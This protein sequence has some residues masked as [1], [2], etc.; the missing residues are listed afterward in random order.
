MPKKET[1]FSRQTV[2]R[3]APSP[4][5]RMHLGNVYTALAAWLCAKSA[6]GDFLLRIE[7]LDPVR[8]PRA[9]ADQILSDLEWLGITWDNPD[10][11]YQSERT[12]IY[13]KYYEQ[14]TGK[15][16]VY[17]CFCSRAQLH[18]A[19]APH[20][21][22]GRVVYAGT[23]RRLTDAEV[24]EKAKQR[25]PAARL[26]LPDTDITF[27]DGCYGPQSFNLA[28]D[29]GDIIIRR[30]DGVF[31]YQL[32]VTIDDGLMGVSQVVRGCDL[33]SSSA[34]QIYLFQTLGFDVP[35]YL[36]L[37][38]LITREGARLAKRDK[39]ADMGF[40]R[41]ELGRP[42]PLLGY[43]AWLLGQI[44]KPEPLKATDILPLFDRKK[45]PGHDLVIPGN[46]W[47]ELKLKS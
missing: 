28:R 16:L 43:I 22:D 46:Y 19:D 14:L 24:R 47:E 9:N 27:C 39:A 30:S 6:G 13:E 7:D 41:Q 18:V 3:F 42:E 36:H 32:A 33:L 31:A 37:P 23:C 5:G 45:I 40:L 34:P 29:W 38:M 35:E 44:S 8:C 25:R 4:S 20:A 11:P 15:N 10:V 2:G 12:V 17:P 21:S 1:V 26:I